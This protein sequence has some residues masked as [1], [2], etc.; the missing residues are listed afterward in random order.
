[1][2]RLNGVRLYNTRCPK[3]AELGKD[4]SGDN[5]VVYSDGHSYCYSCGYYTGS[6]IRKLKSTKKVIQQITLP[7]DISN[8]LPPVPTKWLL[9][10]FTYKDI[11]SNTWW[12][13]SKQY[14]I[15]PIYDDNLKSPNLLAYQAR[16]F[17]DNPEHPKW[18]GYGITDL[19]FHIIGKTTD[20]SSICL[21][22]DLISAYK[23]GHIQ[24]CMPIFGSHIGLSRFAKIKLLG[25]TK[26]YIWLDYDKRS[27]A[28]SEASLG[29]SIGLDTQVIHTTLDPK[30]YSYGEITHILK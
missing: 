20:S 26:V 30:D 6:D 15:F 19:L 11:P 17:G 7:E 8:T 5:L 14:L 13:E 3:C 27:E 22:E 23:V 29:A 1:M 4:R 25:Y 28:I 21:V 10:Y 9:K 24:Q 18:I 2:G 12:S 16:Y